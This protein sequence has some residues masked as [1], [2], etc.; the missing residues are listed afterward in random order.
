MQ[1]RPLQRSARGIKIKRREE[2]FMDIITLLFR[3]NVIMLIYL[4]VGYLLFE[5]EAS[6]GTGKR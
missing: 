5:K 4:L 3:Q 6:D 1:I 2:G